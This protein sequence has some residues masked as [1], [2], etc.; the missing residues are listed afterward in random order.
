MTKKVLI[1]GG[2][3]FLGTNVA[4]ALIKFGY[5]VDLL[6][7]KKKNFKRLKNTNYIFCDIRNK[8]DLKKKIDNNYEYVINFAGNIDHK[9]TQQTF[10][11][12]F[13]AIKNILEILKKRKIKL[14]IQAGSCLEYGKNKSPQKEKERCRPISQYGKSKYYLSKYLI[15]NKKK[16]QFKFIILRLYQVYG[17][18]QKKDRLIPIVIDSCLQ[19]KNFNCTEGNQERD[20][21]YIDDLTTLIKK[22]LN[23]K[24][25]NSNIYNVG[26]GNPIK[27]RNVICKIRKIISKGNPKF[28]AIKMRK[29]EVKFLYPDIKKVKK[30][31][32]WSPKVNIF[33]GL[34]KTIKFYENKKK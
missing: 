10:S 16:F 34:K 20:F 24:K 6:C 1:I 9:N 17:P 21:L 15:K 32:K 22:M 29:D 23:H 14:F 2:K 31:F 33:E 5:N 3:G 8:K 7:K 18:Y 26:S 27:V 30:E 19:N 13:I 11:T 25:I 12:H 4:R 28:G